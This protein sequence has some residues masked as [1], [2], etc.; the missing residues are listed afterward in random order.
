MF[1]MLEMRMRDMRLF[2]VVY[3]LSIQMHGVH[4]M[5][6]EQPFS[7][8]DLCLFNPMC[9][10]FHWRRRNDWSDILQGITAVNDI[11]FVTDFKM[12]SQFKI[13]YYLKCVVVVAPEAHNIRQPKMVAA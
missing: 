11:K 13:L 12:T 7:A 5:S 6:R 2:Y 1:K 4:P 10:K 3:I 9:H 8:F